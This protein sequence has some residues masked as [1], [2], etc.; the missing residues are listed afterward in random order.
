MDENENLEA[1]SFKLKAKNLLGKLV[2][3]AHYILMSPVRI[4]KFI[5][6]SLGLFTFT[7]LTLLSLVVFNFYASL[8]DVS[9][10][11]FPDLKKMAINKVVKKLKSKSKIRKYKWTPIDKINRDLVY[12]IVMS[13]DTSYFTHGG[14]DYNSLLNSLAHNIKKREYS[15]GA[16][17]ISQQVVKNLF[18][19]HGKTLT[20]KLREYFITKRL[21][22]RFSK[23]QILEIYLNIAEFGPDI[24]GVKYASRNMFKK[25]PSEINVAEGAYLGLMLPSPRKHYYIIHQNKNLT[26]KRKKK[27]KRVLRDMVYHEFISYKQYL[28]FIKYRYN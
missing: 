14:I 4:F 7:F 25:E 8:P 11:E 5:C 26:K 21:E 13:E 1:V 12:S 19:N 3:K 16:S 27:I 6:F 15:S 24:Y 28:E 9:K 10:M 23:N 17:T 20:R 2:N 22:A 18:L